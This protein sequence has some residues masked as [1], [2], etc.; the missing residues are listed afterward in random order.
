M[1][2]N[3]YAFGRNLKITTKLIINDIVFLAPVG[4]MF[5]LLIS[6]SGR[7]TKSLIL[8]LAAVIIAV[9]ITVIIIF[10]IRKSIKKINGVFKSLENNDLTVK[11]DIASSDEF[12]ELMNSLGAFLEKLHSAFVSFYKNAN[13]VSGAVFALSSSS[14]EI[15]ATA[16]EQSTTVAEI[17]STMEN[18]K[19]MSSQISEKTVE[20]ADMANLTQELSKRGADIRTVNEEMMNNIRNKN[21]KIIDEIKNLVEMLSRIDESVQLIDTIADQTK[22]IAFNAALEASSS[23]EA[24]IRFA[25]VAGEIRRFADNVVESVVEIKEKINELQEASSSLIIDANNGSKA[26]TEGYNRMIEQKEVFKNIV[27]V[28]QDVASRSQEISTLS[29]QQELA[30]S[31]I[32]SALKEIS[33]GIK[34]FVTVTDSTSSTAD[35]LNSMSNNLQETLANYKTNKQEDKNDSR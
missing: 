4:I 5:F 16:N 12:G 2:K 24:G 18:N 21:N 10:N 7:L 32:F 29:K 30:S 9:V 13:M 8:S 28:S 23:G 31:Q 22:L 25:V 17:V 33:S 15:S 11:V 35:N 3:M 27:E 26:I 34:Q 20:V 1:V 14:K 19:N 6:S